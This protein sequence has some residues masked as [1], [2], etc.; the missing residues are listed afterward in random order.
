M[1]VAWRWTQAGISIVHLG[2]AAA[3]IELEQEFS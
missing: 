1:N 2:G 3:P